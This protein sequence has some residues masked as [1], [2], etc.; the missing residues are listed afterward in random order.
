MHS[1][2]SVLVL[3]VEF[4][5]EAHDGMYMYVSRDVHLPAGAGREGGERRTGQ[6]GSIPSHSH[7]QG[8]ADSK[9]SVPSLQGMWTQSSLTL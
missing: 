1:T 6:G 4:C 8:E 9:E 5:S 7:R 3:E 2:G